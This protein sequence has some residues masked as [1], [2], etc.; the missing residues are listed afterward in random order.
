MKKWI[1]RFLDVVIGGLLTVLIAWPLRVYRKVR[2]PRDRGP[3]ILRWMC[4]LFLYLACYAVLFEVCAPENARRKACRSRRS[5]QRRNLP[6]AR[7]GAS[8]TCPASA[9]SAPASSQTESC[10]ARTSPSCSR[11]P[12]REAPPLDGQDETW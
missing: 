9:W 8:S 5:S 2:G 10:P 12:A 6:R 11:T 3:S 4:A 1:L 7:W